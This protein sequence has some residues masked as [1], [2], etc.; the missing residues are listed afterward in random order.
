MRSGLQPATRT[1]WG[2]CARWLTVCCLLILLGGCQAPRP[3]RVIVPLPTEDL[4]YQSWVAWEHPESGA[5][6]RV[7][8]MLLVGMRYEWA[9]PEEYREMMYADLADLI[10]EQAWIRAVQE[11]RDEARITEGDEH[12]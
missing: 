4:T 8:R 7:P 12:D 1:T 11:A 5:V 6:Y 2:A 10:R 3:I 9:M